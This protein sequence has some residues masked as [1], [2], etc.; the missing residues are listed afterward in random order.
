MNR[1]CRLHVSLPVLFVL[2][3]LFVAPASALAVSSAL[4]IAIDASGSID[5][6]EF[7]LQRQIYADFF[8]NNADAFDG[9]DLNATVVYWAGNGVQVQA[10]PWTSIDSGGAAQAFADAIAATSRPDISGPDAAM[11]GVARALSFTTGLFEGQDFGEADL[12][13]DISG[14]GTENLDTATSA[15]LDTVFLDLPEFGPTPFDVTA[16]WGAAF[17]ARQEALDAGILINALPIIPVPPDPSQPAE[18]QDSSLAIDFFPAPS[19]IVNG[20]TV[21]VSAEWEAALL[22][23]FGDQTLL[24]AF[25]SRVVGSPDARVPILQVANGLTL[26]ELTAAVEAKLGQETGIPVP[27]PGAAPLVGIG[28]L[29]VAFRRSRA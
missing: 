29:F 3:A 27:A 11:T 23:L 13:I 7:A 21:D 18:A 2:A 19:V 6:D 26:E 25:Y 15:V 28:L 10:V 1:A 9:A 20:E 22:A 4:A 16:P 17:E 14:D 8:A 12:V 24:E 5:N